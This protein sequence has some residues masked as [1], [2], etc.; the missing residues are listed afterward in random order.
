MLTRP[1]YLVWPRGRMRTNLCVIYVSSRSRNTPYGE[2]SGHPCRGTALGGGARKRQR[3]SGAPPRGPR[4]EWERGPVSGKAGWGPGALGLLLP[5]SWAVQAF[6]A[7]KAFPGNQAPSS[8]LCSPNRAAPIALRP[9][10][11]GSV[12]MGMLDGRKG[13]NSACCCSSAGDEEKGAELLPPRFCKKA[14]Q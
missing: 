13:W 10:W 5:P 7:R 1:D 9:R 14:E 12:G 4:R 6:P 8:L 3:C 11:R 2:H